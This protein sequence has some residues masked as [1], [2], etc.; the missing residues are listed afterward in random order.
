MFYLFRGIKLN[1][2]MQ[3]CS[4]QEAYNVDSFPRKKKKCG[5][6]KTPAT[7]FNPFTEQSGYEQAR[8]EQF[9][10]NEVSTK[11]LARQDKMGLRDTVSYSGLVSDYDYMCNNYNICSLTEDFKNSPANE[12]RKSMKP[13]KQVKPEDKCTP[14]EPP[15]YKYPISAED[16]AKFQKALK[17]AL[18][19]MESSTPPYKPLKREVNMSDVSGYVEDD[20][21]SSFMMVNDMKATPKESFPKLE[22][23]IDLPGFDKGITASPFIK[24]VKKN[25]ILLPKN[26]TNT[27]KLWMDLLL[28]ISS[29]ILI[30]FLLEQLY[31][32]AIMTGTKKT[33]ILLD[34][35]I[36]H[37]KENSI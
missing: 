5:A 14:L 1:N 31:K 6:E 8:I 22:P 12:E 13:L 3:Y 4:L 26:Y 29:G 32:I 30:I 11:P 2:K 27:H 25:D 34:N 16:K 20:E 17:V 23:T 37:L 35:I 15:I 7:P 19:N 33:I 9:Q 36:R 24:D 21:L 10:N 28:F 18:E